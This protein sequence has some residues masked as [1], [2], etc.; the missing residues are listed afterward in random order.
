MKEDVRN[1][2]TVVIENLFFRYNEWLQQWTQ[3]RYE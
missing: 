2:I 1:Q 3:P